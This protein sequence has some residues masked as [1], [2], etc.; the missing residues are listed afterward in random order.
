MTHARAVIIAVLALAAVA[1]A[2]WWFGPNE[3]EAPTAERVDTGE[4]ESVMIRRTE[5]G[6]EPRTVSIAVGDT[7]QFVNDTDRDHWPASDVHPTHTVYSAFDPREP[8]GP[9][10]TWSFTF[11][12]AGEWHFH[13]HLRANVT[14]TVT[15]H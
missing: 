5:A 3:A 7:V 9:G 10:D 12:R 13:D 15:V 14:G 11:D 2:V 6:Y 4:R 1:G 8:I